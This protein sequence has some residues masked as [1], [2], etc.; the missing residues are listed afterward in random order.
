MHLFREVMVFAVIFKTHVSALCH[1]IMPPKP[2]KSEAQLRKAKKTKSEAQLQTAKK[3]MQKLEKK[4]QRLP[5][6]EAA[7]RDMTLLVNDATQRANA[8]T[9]RANA[10]TQRNVTLEGLLRDAMH[11]ANETAAEN[12]RMRRRTGMLKQALRISQ[13][14]V[15]DLRKSLEK[16]SETVDHG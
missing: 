1:K 4:V 14:D 7:L 6:L 12:A 5:A 16:V 2:H 13:T 8:A 15:R 11:T 10:A 3:T 9:Q